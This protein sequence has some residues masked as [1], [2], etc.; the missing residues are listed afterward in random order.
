MKHHQE[1]KLPEQALLSKFIKDPGYKME[2]VQSE[3][4]TVKHPYNSNQLDKYAQL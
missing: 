4:R 2:A 1:K 3:A